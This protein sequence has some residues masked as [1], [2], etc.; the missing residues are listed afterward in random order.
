MEEG[1]QRLSGEEL[2]RIHDDALALGAGRAGSD[3]ARVVSNTFSLLEEIDRLAGAL[4]DERQG[5]E[6]A[7]RLLDFERRRLAQLGDEALA[8][9]VVALQEDDR[10]W[11]RA[12]VRQ[13]R[14]VRPGAEAVLVAP[15]SSDADRR[16]AQRVLDDLHDAEDALR[17]F[18]E[19]PSDEQV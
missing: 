8:D 5:R 1:P 13:A 12:I 10:A 2:E 17:G 16:A 3:V 14:F 18:D 11:V 6:L 15:S 9:Q 7:L 19:G 4:D